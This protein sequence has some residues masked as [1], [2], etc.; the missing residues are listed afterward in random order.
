MKILS[1]DAKLLDVMHN[2]LKRKKLD[3][4]KK[5]EKK[6]GAYG[7]IATY[8]DLANLTLASIGILF[9]YLSY[10]Q[11]QK[12]NFVH[13]KYKP[14][15]NDGIELKFENLTKEERTKKEHQL[16][17]DILEKKLEYIFVG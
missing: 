9:T 3:N 13:F 8:I 1:D 14:Q 10:R 11:N 15:Y 7:D 4:Y 6:E 5:T 17:D 2:E 16:K 12:N